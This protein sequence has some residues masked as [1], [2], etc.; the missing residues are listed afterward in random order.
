M[1]PV[2]G[3]TSTRSCPTR[4]EDVD[5]QPVIEMVVI[6]T[7]TAR[8]VDTADG[9]ARAIG[10]YRYQTLVNI[11]VISQH[12]VLAYEAFSTLPVL[13]VAGCL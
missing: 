13:R 9:I 11:H 12:R 2:V 7:C 1:K 10:R 4:L 8:N 5:N 6:P 3:L